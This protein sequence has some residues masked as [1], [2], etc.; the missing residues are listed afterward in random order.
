MKIYH[1]CEICRQ[2]FDTSEMEGYEGS[3]EMQGM[4]DDCSQEMG[5]AES[6]APPR[7]FFYH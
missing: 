2:V 7:Q 6:S 4:C 1:V 5:F 3:M